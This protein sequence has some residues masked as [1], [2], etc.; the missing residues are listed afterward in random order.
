MNFTLLKLNERLDI[1]SR[2]KPYWNRRSQEVHM[3]RNTW[4]LLNTLVNLQLLTGKQ[5]QEKSKTSLAKWIEAQFDN[6][7]KRNRYCEEQYID[8]YAGFELENFDAYYTRRKA[9]NAGL[10]RPSV[11]L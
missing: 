10:F 9:N 6:V 8:V 7:D 1:F 5:N 11:I 3:H 4:E 2:T